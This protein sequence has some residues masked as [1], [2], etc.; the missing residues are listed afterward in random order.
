MPPY[1]NIQLYYFAVANEPRGTVWRSD[2]INSDRL[3]CRREIYSRKK[4][5]R[6]FRKPPTSC[7][8]RPFFLLRR[9]SRSSPTGLCS[10]NLVFFLLAPDSRVQ[11]VV[12][13]DQ[14]G[15]CPHPPP[16]Q[17]SIRPRLRALGEETLP[18]SGQ[19]ALGCHP[20]TTADGLFGLGQGRHRGGEGGGAPGTPL[21][22]R[23]ALPGRLSRPNHSLLNNSACSSAVI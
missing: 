20:H 9:Q 1:K 19:E 6:C 5:P 3:S 17:I 21:P 14:R 18:P 2:R 12:R 15:G 10:C 11:K 13:V 4:Q 7:V 23:A 16:P 8:D 22:L